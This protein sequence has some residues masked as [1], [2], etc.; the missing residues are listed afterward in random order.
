V[1]FIKVVE[2]AKNFNMLYVNAS[3]TFVIFVGI[4]AINFVLICGFLIG[5][6]FSAFSYWFICYGIAGLGMIAWFFITIN[7]IYKGA[8][9]SVDDEIKDPK[10]E[11]KEPPPVLYRNIERDYGCGEVRVGTYLD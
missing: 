4:P 7:P 6:D 9:K 2:D 11:R 3:I 10:K 8:K 1:G 5:Y